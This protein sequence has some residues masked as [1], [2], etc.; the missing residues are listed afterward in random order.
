[1]NWK[2][3]ASKT[4]PPSTHTPTHANCTVSLVRVSGTKTKLLLNRWCDNV[5]VKNQVSKDTLERLLHVSVTFLGCVA[6]CD[7]AIIPVKV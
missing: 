2:C 3:H 7:T 1:M 6:V 5:D 4:N